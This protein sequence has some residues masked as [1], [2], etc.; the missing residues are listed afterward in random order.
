MGSAETRRF[1][2]ARYDEYRRILTEL[3]LARSPH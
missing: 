2:D 3:R 1:L